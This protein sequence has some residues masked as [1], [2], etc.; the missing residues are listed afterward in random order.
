MMPAAHSLD[1]SPEAQMFWRPHI[2]AAALAAALQDEIL[3]MLEAEAAH[4]E[5]EIDGV[6]ERIVKLIGLLEPFLPYTDLQHA[7]G[8]VL[9]AYLAR[10]EDNGAPT[11]LDKQVITASIAY[12]YEKGTNIPASDLTQELKKY[13]NTYV[14][15]IGQLYDLLEKTQ[16]KTRSR[17]R[18]YGALKDDLHLLPSG[19]LPVYEDE[20]AALAEKLKGLD[21]TKPCENAL[22]F[23]QKN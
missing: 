22:M 2:R 17:D 23:Q 16:A 5:M 6:S 3:N 1:V 20:V 21:M 18:N 14:P 10:V 15:F 8:S 4:D 13:R 9:L 11:A 12:L 7:A 19:L